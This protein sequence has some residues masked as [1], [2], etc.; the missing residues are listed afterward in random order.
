MGRFH[1]IVKMN[2]FKLNS[3][4]VRDPLFS[5][6]LLIGHLTSGIVVEMILSLYSENT[7][8]WAILAMGTSELCPVTCALCPQ[9]EMCQDIP[10]KDLF[11]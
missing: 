8:Q 7:S 5:R 6:S 4:E 3:C 10:K 1:T 2:D 11:E 9:A